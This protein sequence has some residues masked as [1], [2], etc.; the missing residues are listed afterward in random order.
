[1]KKLKHKEVLGIYYSLPILGELKGVKF[2][3]GIDKN[4]KRL[5]K[6]VETLEERAKPSKEFEEYDKERVKVNEKF[7][8]KNEDGTPKMVTNQQ[9][10]V[11]RYVIDDKRKT[12]FDKEQ[13]ELKI[14]HKAAV[15]SREAQ[16]KEYRE[17]LEGESDFTPFFIDIDSVPTEIN[18]NQFELISIFFKEDEVKEESKEDKSDKETK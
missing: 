14:K 4:R 13:D 16:L 8:Q 2:N 9:Q 10:Q 6:E 12:E 7:S 15:E 1:M 18:G 3:Y 5:K 17:F 11:S